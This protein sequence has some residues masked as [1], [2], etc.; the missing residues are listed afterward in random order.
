MTDSDLSFKIWTY[1]QTYQS[2]GTDGICQLCGLEVRHHSE[3]RFRDS[4]RSPHARS[5]PDL[6]VANHPNRLVLVGGFW[7]CTC[8]TNRNPRASHEPLCTRGRVRHVG[9][10]AHGDLCRRSMGSFAWRAQF[11][12]KILV[13][14]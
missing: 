3:I 1:A 8:A 13:A 9:H 11:E 10:F 5:T 14:M 6:S 7:A 2:H 12:V 4:E